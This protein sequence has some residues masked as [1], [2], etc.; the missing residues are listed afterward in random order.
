MAKWLPEAN[1]ARMEALVAL[2]ELPLDI[3]GFGPVKAKNEAQAAK[4]REAL[5]AALRDGG[6]DSGSTP[7]PAQ[8]AE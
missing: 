5:L 2:A 8:A 3:R 6:R 4:R 7:M 1:A